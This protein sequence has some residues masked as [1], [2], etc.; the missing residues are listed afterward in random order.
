MLGGGNF[1][2]TTNSGY[3][4]QQINFSESGNV[5]SFSFIN[6]DTGWVVIAHC[7]E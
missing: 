2:K 1:W 6:K 3:N 4:W 5:N 7:L